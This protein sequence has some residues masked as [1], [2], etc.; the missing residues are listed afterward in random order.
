[1]KRTILLVAIFLVLAST[2]FGAPVYSIVTGHWY[3]RVDASISWVDAKAVAESRSFNGAQGYLATITSDQE[4]RWIV[5][6]LGGAATLDHWLGGYN[7]QGTWKW[8]TGETWSY[9]NWW[10]GEPNGTI[11]YILQFDDNEGNPPV[12]GYWNDY[13]PNS[14]EPG[15]IVEYNAPAPV[16]LPSAIWLFGSGLAGIMGYIKLKGNRRA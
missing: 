16:P 9:T 11:G 5:D 2:S 12:P 15:Y 14:P 3:E 8:V 6:N 1:M 4:N 7:D 10:P 13:D